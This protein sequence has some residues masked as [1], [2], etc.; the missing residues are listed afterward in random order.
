M[1]LQDQRALGCMWHQPKDRNSLLYLKFDQWY[2]KPG[3][4]ITVLPFH[5]PHQRQGIKKRK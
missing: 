5:Q 1:W 3:S 2:I 4:K